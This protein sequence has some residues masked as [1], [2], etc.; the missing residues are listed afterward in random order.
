MLAI[1]VTALKDDD[2]LLA[3]LNRALRLVATSD[4]CPRD[5]VR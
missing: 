2:P 1:A 5:I 3:D 4:H